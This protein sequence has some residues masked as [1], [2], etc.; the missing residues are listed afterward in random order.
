MGQSLE[1]KVKACLEDTCEKE[2]IEEMS[3]YNFS[4]EFNYAVILFDLLT[5]ETQLHSKDIYIN[6]SLKINCAVP[7]IGKNLAE[8]YLNELLQNHKTCCIV[9]VKEGKILADTIKFCF[10]ELVK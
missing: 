1:L 10:A 4:E 7:F 2:L 8:S 9:E 3:S 6:I 5:K